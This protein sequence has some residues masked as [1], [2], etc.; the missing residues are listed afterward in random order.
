ME[1]TT[2]ISHQTSTTTT[3]TD[4]WKNAEANIY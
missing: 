4:I 3:A 2:S 1:T